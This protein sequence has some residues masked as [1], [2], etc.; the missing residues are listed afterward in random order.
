VDLSRARIVVYTAITGGRDT[1][2][3]DQCFEGAD[4]VAFTDLDAPASRW[5]VRRAC[6]A[7]DSPRA[8]AKI[9]KVLPQL[10]LHGYEYSLWIDGSIRLLRP[11]REL[12]QLYLAHTDLAVFRHPERDCLYDEAEVCRAAGL[13]DSAVIDYQIRRYS[14]EGY[15]AHNGLIAAGVI[16]R[17]HTPAIERFS[18]AWWSEICQGSIRDQLSIN[19]VLHSLGMTPAYFPDGIYTSRYFAFEGHAM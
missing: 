15:P 2:K 11:I 18:N 5:Q 19:Y 3:G 4:F 14:A 17:R 13:D 8:N 12:I 16:L 1:L 7:F 9:H 6:T 10:Y